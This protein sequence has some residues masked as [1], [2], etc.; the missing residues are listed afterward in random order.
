M[1]KRFPKLHDLF[2]RGD[3]FMK[4]F[5]LVLYSG[6]LSIGP[7]SAQEVS[8]FAFNIGGGFTQPVGNTGRHLDD[9]WN[10]QAGAGVNLNAYL[11]AL[12]QFDYNGMGINSTTLNN[13]G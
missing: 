6:L 9:G 10:I 2:Y 8:R 5:A 3:L 1:A 12:V 11:G 7:L 4:A 13:L